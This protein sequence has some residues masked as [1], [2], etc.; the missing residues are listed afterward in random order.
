MPLE[1][2]NDPTTLA[3]AALTATLKDERRAQ[4]FLELTGIGTDE[5]RSGLGNPRLLAAVLSF[6]EAHEP[7]LVAVAEEVG[8][9]PEALVRAR[10]ELEA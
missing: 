3:L 7:D 8:V 1:S 4:R 5:L 2:P 9:K 10:Q 6:L